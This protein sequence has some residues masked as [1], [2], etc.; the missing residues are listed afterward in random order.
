MEQERSQY[1]LRQRFGF[2][3]VIL[4][5]SIIGCALYFIL[6][7][8]YPI[9]SGFIFGLSGSGFMWA[10]VEIIDFFIEIHRIFE[11]ERSRFFVMVENYWSQL[12]DI[13]RVAADAKDVKWEEVFDC[14]DNLYNDMT[15]FPFQGGIYSISKEFEDAVIYITR[16]YWKAHGYANSREKR[17]TRDYW[18]AFYNDFVEVSRNHS[19]TSEKEIREFTTINRK[20]DELRRIEVSFDDFNHP[21]DMI[22]YQ[23]YGDLGRSLSFT[24]GETQYRTFKPA[25]DFHEKFHIDA[26]YSVFP[27]VCELLSRKIKK[28]D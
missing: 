28:W 2:R 4:I 16:L 19:R 6:D 13:F 1:V 26:Q 22:N 27:V 12:R 11:E 5:L 23:D 7:A 21:E 10:L 9:L 25:H 3:V 24:S 15:R 20:I 8:D 14:I 17:N 18:K